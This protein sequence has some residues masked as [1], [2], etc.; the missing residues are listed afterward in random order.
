MMAMAVW[1]LFASKTTKMKYYGKCFAK[2]A[3]VFIYMSL[4]VI[5]G[6][7]LMAA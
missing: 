1:I 3:E 2:N 7:I 4:M 5:I 6:C